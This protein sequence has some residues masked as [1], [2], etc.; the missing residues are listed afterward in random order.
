MCSHIP[1]PSA[2]APAPSRRGFLFGASAAAVSGV[3]GVVAAA[4]PAS[5][6]T[7][8]RGDQPGNAD[9][10]R[11]QLV[12]LGT[13]GGPTLL[14]DD[15]A[16]VSTAVVY[17]GK[18]YIVDLG[19]G[20]PWQF[21]RAGLAGS[22]APTQWMT[23]VRGIFFTH[24]HSD[25]T[26][27]WPAT[28]ATASSNLLPGHPPIH[29]FGP[30][31]RGTLPAVF[32]PMRPAPP[33][34]EADDPTPG[35]AGMTAHLQR[36]FA[37]D[38]NDRVRDSAMVPP[39]AHFVINE[40]DLSGV[41][42]VDP[43]GVPPVLERPLQVWQDGDVTVTATLVDHHPT[44]PAYAYRF[45]TP[46]GSIVISGDTR[47]SENLINLAQG[48]DYLVH[49]VIDPGF[50]EQITAGLPPEQAGPIRSH[51]L[52]AHTTIEQVGRDVAELAGAKN[53]V[54][55][56]IVPGHADDKTLR[57]AGVGYNGNLIIGQDLMRI[58]VGTKKK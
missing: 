55:S 46:D 54:L 22:G 11:T 4:S 36:A 43:A 34:I 38:L 25:H 41:W 47:P 5:A 18:V 17:D 13:G 10:F 28:W 15:R 20:A 21:M 29:V 58:G 39:S 9:K 8:S 16:G 3:V 37:Q 51:L 50:V 2:T 12:L 48:V 26:I 30:G 42:D 27:E 32:P 1:I 40:I 35:I 56:H 45:D 7:A 14:T 23:N 52:G 57:Q 19:H 44:A 53:L 31:P 49:E 6:S 24:L 33:L